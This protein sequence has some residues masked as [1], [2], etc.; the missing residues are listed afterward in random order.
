MLANQYLV[1]TNTWLAVKLRR[2]IKTNLYLQKT[3]HGQEEI[4]G[5]IQNNYYHVFIDIGHNTLQMKGR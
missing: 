2:A 3:A 4:P 5:K 1:T